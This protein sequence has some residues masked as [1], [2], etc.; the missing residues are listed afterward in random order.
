MAARSLNETAESNEKADTLRLWFTAIAVLV[1]CVSLGPPL[2]GYLGSNDGRQ[3]L[4]RVVAVFSKPALPIVVSK[5][6]ST[7][8]EGAVLVFDNQTNRQITVAVIVERGGQ[9]AGKWNVPVPPNGSSEFGWAEGWAF[10]KGDKF[11]L[12]HSDFREYRSSLE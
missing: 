7:V 5:R 2:I 8:G 4:G 12:S 9:V 1:A 10:T 11:S 3:Q 6:P